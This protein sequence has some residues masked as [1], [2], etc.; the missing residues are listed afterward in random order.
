MSLKN[1]QKP[2]EKI[3]TFDEVWQILKETARHQKEIS[4]QQKESHKAFKEEMKESQMK[5]DKDMKESR[6][7]FDKKMNKMHG[8][9]SNAWGDFVESLVSGSLVKMLQE[10][11]P[12]VN[13]IMKNIECHRNGLDCE[14]DIIAVNNDALVAVEVKSTLNI[15]DVNN[16]L[17]KLQSFIMFFPQ[18]KN[19]KVYGAV[20]YLKVTQSADKFAMKQGLFVIRATADSGEILNKKGAFQPKVIKQIP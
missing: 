3:P 16:F 1:K 17:E 13:Q 20:A 4:K 10:W 8:I 12:S 14:I 2:K 6:I 18:Y 11:I 19:Y 9:W 5:F 15:K 7:E